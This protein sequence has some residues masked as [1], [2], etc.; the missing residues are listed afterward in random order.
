MK[1][2]QFIIMALGGLA[3]VTL[4]SAGQAQF[5]GLG[6]LIKKAPAI[7]APKFLSGPQPISTNI[8]DAIYADPSHDQF[9]PGTAVALTNLARDAR[10][11]FVLK[12]GYYLMLAQSYCLHAGT[13]GPTAGDG[14][15]F[16]P[17]KGTARDAVVSILQNSVAHPEI[18][19][20]DI[21]MLLWA[22]VAKASFE[23]LDNRLKVVAAQLLTTRQLA[24]LNHNA[25]SVLTSPELARLTGGM[26]APLRAV[27]EAESRLR[28][29]FS[30]GTSSYA[31]MERIAVLAGAAPRGPGS[32]DVPAT[33]WSLQPD[34][35]WV[36]YRPNGYTNT[37]VEV[38]VAP[39]S[40][41][42][43]KSYDPGQSIATPGDTGRQRLAQSGRVYGR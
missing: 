21:Q 22:I 8:A 43:G 40:A 11:G 18:D 29:M 12:P 30:S 16:A 42:V 13:R 14:Y 20:H 25:L 33:R 9:T 6:N 39:G 31:D 38:Y 35:Y 26:P 34:G 32:V 1:P 19:Q 3:L 41:A 37:Q 2:K 17:V 4:T 24:T 7:A 5:G 10:G 36:R 27:A 23:N 28:G 15:L